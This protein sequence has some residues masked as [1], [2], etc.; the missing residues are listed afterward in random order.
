MPPRGSYSDIVRI[1]RGESG[2]VRLRMELTIRFGYGHTIPWVTRLEDGCLRAVAG[3]DMILL[4]T[5]A[6]LHGEG[7]STVSEFT[8]AA[9]ECVP[10]VMTYGP[11]HHPPPDP[12]DPFLALEETD[13]FWSEW[14]A[15]YDPHRLEASD[16]LPPHWTGA[17][18]RSLVVLKALTYAPTGGI[19]AAPTTS[20]PEWPGGPRNWDYRYCWLRD[21]AITLDALMSGG[22][23]EEAEAWRN[24][25]IRAMAGSVDQMQIMFGVAGER[26]LLEWEVAW[27]PGFEQSRPVRIGNAAAAQLQLDVF[28]EVMLLLDQARR[29]GLKEIPEAWALQKAML[30]RLETLWREPDEG[31]WEVRGG[32]RHFTFSKVMAWAAFD[33]CIRS[34][35]DF[36]LDDAPLERWRT[37]RDE[38]IATSA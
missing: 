30:A 28:G 11:S 18:L 31:I 9:G 10:F 8:V 27:L 29:G 3:P 6:E 20:L 36:G 32:R 5:P 2:A 21:A 4:R 12:V 38:I 16:R 33:R 24:W 7:M 37:I 22:Y 1:V 35:Q 34:A 25:L 15:R 19:V 17:I 13:A 14:A 23:L 26:R